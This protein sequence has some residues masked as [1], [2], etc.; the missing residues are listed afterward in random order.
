M[1]EICRRTWRDAIAPH[2]SREGLEALAHALRLDDDTVMQG[3]TV[4]PPPPYCNDW[5]PFCVC[6]AAYG[7]WK[8]NEA[9]RTVGQLDTAFKALQLQVD[10][11]MGEPDAFRFFAGWWDLTEREEARRELLEEVDLAIARRRAVA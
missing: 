10:R 7:L 4:S 11:V 5:E 1:L 8:G 3:G 9:V 2:L 6:P